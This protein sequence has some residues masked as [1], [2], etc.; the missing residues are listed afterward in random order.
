MRPQIR[1]PI[2]SRLGRATMAA[3]LALL[4]LTALATVDMTACED[5][6]WPRVHLRTRT[7]QTRQAAAR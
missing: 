4:L 2:D 6:G 3:R 1:R 5:Q 7:I